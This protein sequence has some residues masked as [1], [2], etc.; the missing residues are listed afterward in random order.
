MV[1]FGTAPIAV[2]SLHSLAGSDWCRLAGVITQPDRPKGRNLAPQPPAVK[3]AAEA[4]GIPVLQP[5]RSRDPAFLPLL[6]SLHPEVLVVMAYGQILSQALLDLPRWG[7]L[8]IHT[9]LL[10]KYRGAAPI[11]R[12]LL[13]GERESGVTIIRMDAGMDSGDILSM[14]TI[15]IGPSETFLSLENKFAEA[16]ARLIV[17]TVPK[18]VEGR[19]EPRPQP[20]EGVSYAPKIRKEEGRLSW[21]ASAEDLRNKIRAFQPWPGAFCY[22]P[23][24]AQRRLLKIWE[25]EASGATGLAGQ[26]LAA[27]QAGIVVGCGEGALTIIRLQK[28]GGR[29]LSAADF[30][31]GHPLQ[32]GTQFV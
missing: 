23:E 13:A 18:Y 12:A 25:A 10:P 26:V 17:E 11:Q 5:E 30:L 14:R 15:P 20:L 6:E 24:G 27:D 21:T 9:S 28:E 16:G 2:P 29:I 32:P 31:R 1:F 22:Y 8:N 3:Q 19:I 4:L 7:G